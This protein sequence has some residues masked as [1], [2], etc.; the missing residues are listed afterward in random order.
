MTILNGGAMAPGDGEMALESEPESYGKDR[1]KELRKRRNSPL[2][3][4]P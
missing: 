3:I 1:R 4:S 2:D